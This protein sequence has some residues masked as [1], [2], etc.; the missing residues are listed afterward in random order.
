MQNKLTL[1]QRVRSDTPAFFKRAQLFG[2]G[3]VSL[4]TSL[5][6]VAGI[7]AKLTT[8]LISAGSTITIIAQFAVKQYQPLNTKTDNDIK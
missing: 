8:I 5:G 1:W 7:S 4:G 2:I 6:Q 3:L